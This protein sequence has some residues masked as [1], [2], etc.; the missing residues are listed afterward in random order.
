MNY[1]EELEINC[2]Y[3][4]EFFSIVVEC[5]VGNQSY[6][7]DCYVCCRPVGLFMKIGEEGSVSVEARREN[8]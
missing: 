8:E 5:F 3:C 4:G 7:E 6:I 2:P 1:V